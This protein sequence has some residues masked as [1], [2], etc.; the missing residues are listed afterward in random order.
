M[1]CLHHLFPNLEVIHFE[2]CDLREASQRW[3]LS[4]LMEFPQLR[5]VLHNNRLVLDLSERFRVVVVGEDGQDSSDLE[6][7]DQEEANLDKKAKSEA[8]KAEMYKL[9]RVQ[10]KQL[11]ANRIAAP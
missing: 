2:D 8:K 7:N 9:W 1:H 5:Q 10:I 4:K 3:L 6:H 11:Y